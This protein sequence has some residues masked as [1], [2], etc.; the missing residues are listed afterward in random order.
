MI[1]L[2][3]INPDFETENNNENNK[4]DSSPTWYTRAKSYDWDTVFSMDDDIKNSP[5][6]HKLDSVEIEN[7]YGSTK[8]QIQ[9]LID[10]LVNAK[11]SMEK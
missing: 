10:F 4:L 9:Q 6:G 7:Y 11:E 2:R 1:R 8:D 5:I 3:I